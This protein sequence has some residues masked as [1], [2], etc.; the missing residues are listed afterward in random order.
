MKLDENLLRADD[1]KQCQEIGGAAHHLGLEGILAP[2]ATGSGTVLA[3]FV[4]RL[5]PDSQ[6]ELVKTT[7]WN[8]VAGRSDAG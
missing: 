7:V 1:P 6:L 3:V 4:E 5:L 2:S 8:S